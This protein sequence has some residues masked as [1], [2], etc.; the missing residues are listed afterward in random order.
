MHGYF[1]TLLC[2]LQAT[3]VQSQAQAKA[4]VTNLS[5]PSTMCLLSVMIAL[6]TCNNIN[7]IFFLLATLHVYYSEKGLMELI[8][9]LT[10]GRTVYETNF[11]TALTNN[12]LKGFFSISNY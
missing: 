12:C 11:K 5:R 1:I 3:F 4:I 2:D 6:L 8:I 10:L 9:F 7:L